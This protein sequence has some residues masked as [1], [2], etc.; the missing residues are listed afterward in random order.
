[1]LRVAENLLLRLFGIM[2]IAM[3]VALPKRFAA[4]AKQ[5]SGKDFRV[6]RTI[7]MK[8]FGLLKLKGL[9]F[10][11]VANA[12][13]LWN[14]E[15]TVAGIS[16]YEDALDMQDLRIP[17]ED[18]HNL[19]FNARTNQLFILGE[20]NTSL[21]EIPVDAKGLPVPDTGASPKHDL[22]SMDLQSPRGLTIDPASGR[23]F[24]LNADGNELVTVAP[25]A[26]GKFDGSVAAHAGRIT[27]ISLNELGAAGL[28]GIAFNPAN[29]NVYLLDVVGHRLYEVTQSAKKISEFDLSSLQLTEPQAIVFAPSV[30][31]TD[32]PETQ[33]L[34]I[35]DEAPATTSKTSNFNFASFQSAEETS[36]QLVEISLA[37]PAALPSGTPLLATTLVKT[38]DMSNKAWN[39]SSPDPAGIDYWPQMK[40]FLTTDSEV[41]E[42]RPYWAGANVFAATTSGNLL[43]TCDTTDFTNEPTGIAINPETNRIYISDD[44]GRLYEVN[45][46]SDGNYCTPDDVITSR[47]ISTDLEDVAYG[48]NTLFLAGGVDAEVWMFN[49]GPNRVMGGGD[50]GALIHFD[51]ASKG[52]H[53]VEGIGYKTDADTI[54]VISSDRDEAY[55]GE[56]SPSG[57]LL[58]TYDVS[59]MGRA[60]NLRSD[61][62]YAPG[63]GNTTIKNFYIVSRGIDNGQ[64]RF[65]NDGKWWEISIGSTPV[66]TSI[67]SRTPTIVSTPTATS[68]QTPSTTITNTPTSTS[69]P[70]A[71]PDT[72][73]WYVH[74]VGD[75]VYGKSG[76]IPVVAD[77]NG[78]GKD[79]IAVF[80]PSNSTWYVRGVGDFVY[81][82]VGDIPVVADY[83]GDGKDD[84]AVFRPSNSTWYVRGVGDF[85]YGTVG[86]IPVVADYNGDGK[87]EIAVFRPSTSTWYVRG[88]GDF[89]YGTVG[90]IPVVADYNGDG[91]ADIAVFRS[92]TSTWYIRGV[93]DF[94]YG[95]VG[96]IPVV[97][98]Y[99]GDGRDDIAVFRT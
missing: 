7:Q 40:R 68:T 23:M 99:N 88:V 21:D 15:G 81:G 29:G 26:A 77:Y 65:E 5:D 70:T 45:L 34:F 55:I 82:T 2:I 18:A 39:P 37:A 10:S 20:G 13:L 60:Y 75:F 30:D 46:G 11:P 72:D 85:V 35:L 49:L 1:M 84:I 92:S 61:I 24:V 50:D 56:M 41:E 16:M 78:D 27:R 76:D 86:D 25:D 58:R 66:N 71:S 95:T 80:R 52:F 19:A 90:D 3:L 8:E 17:V 14:A 44:G 54:L 31:R 32:E 42:M 79:D 64:D 74:R 97:A 57:T 96:D 73:N 98:D 59:F 91:K 12:F 67:P 63:S 22:E 83:N 6:V 47:S 87:A 38:V 4:S 51:T 94:L 93:G 62:T 36:G 69:I 9:A 48:N 89:V 53:D 28:Q 43:S 33:N